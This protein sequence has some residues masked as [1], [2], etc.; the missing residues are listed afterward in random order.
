M[1]GLISSPGHEFPTS[2]AQF[3]SLTGKTGSKTETFIA[4]HST[5]VFLSF[6][7]EQSQR[8]DLQLSEALPYLFS[9]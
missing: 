7:S 1:H 3:S 4:A 5:G 9:T 8:N 2:V 6:P